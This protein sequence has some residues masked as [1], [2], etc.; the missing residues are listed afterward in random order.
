MI[1]KEI[2]TWKVRVAKGKN[3]F[4]AKKVRTIHPVVDRI[5]SRLIEIDRIKYE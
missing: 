5:V 4:V 3:I 1:I 2:E